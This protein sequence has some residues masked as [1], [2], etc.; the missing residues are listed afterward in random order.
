MAKKKKPLGL[1]FE[2]L[3]KRKRQPG[4]HN[5]EDFVPDPE[6]PSTATAEDLEAL[7]ADIKDLPKMME[8]QPFIA[9]GDTGP[10]HYMIGGNKRLVCFKILGVKYIPGPWLKILTEAG[11]WSQD[12]K[13]NVAVKANN[14]RGKW[15][16]SRL[17]GKRWGLKRAK[18]FGLKPKKPKPVAKTRALFSPAVSFGLNKSYDIPP[19]KTKAFIKVLPNPVTPYG[20]VARSTQ[21][22]GTYHFYV[23]D[24][25]FKAVFA[26]PDKLYKTA[27]KAII[28][29]NISLA[30]DMPE[31][32][33]IYA[34]FKKRWFTRYLQEYGIKSAVDLHVPERFS[35]INLLGVPKGW[36]AY[37][38][39]GV[40][41]DLEAV[42]KEYKLAQKHSGRQ[43]PIFICVGGGKEIKEFINNSGSVFIRQYQE[44]RKLKK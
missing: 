44:A 13:D 36:P 16:W 29:P 32:Y 30:D 37:A 3:L 23:D 33:A 28:E 14:V 39:R 34:T 7:K 17:A 11:G 6:N 40:R 19:L 41:N 15:N 24:N 21:G 35:K 22:I 2:A 25:K 8:L 10:P 12:D 43:D 20:S 26:D 18:K 42:K 1:T 4:D 5:L 9:D 38:T 27:I 31:A